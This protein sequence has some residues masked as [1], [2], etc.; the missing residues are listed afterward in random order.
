VSTDDGAQQPNARG[1]LHLLPLRDRADF[2]LIAL[3]NALLREAC[4]RLQLTFPGYRLETMKAVSMADALAEEYETSEEDAAAIDAV[5]EEACPLPG[6]IPEDMIPGGRITARTVELLTRLAAAEPDFALAPLLWRLFASPVG[7][8]RTA[9]AEA[10]VHHFDYLDQLAAA[11]PQDEAGAADPGEPIEPEEPGAQDVPVALQRQVQAAESRAGRLSADVEATRKQLDA[12]R[13][14]SAQKDQRLSR[15]KQ[16]LEQVRAEL[17]ATG[18]AKAA[19]EAERD[20]D[21]RALLRKRESELEDTKREAAALQRRLDEANR[22]EA[23]ALA[24]LRS[25]EAPP[26]APLPAPEEVAA[27]APEP[28]SAFRVPELTREFYESIEEWDERTLRTTFEKIL[29]LARNLAHPSL[30]AKPIE[31]AEGLYRIKIGTDVRL[32]Y[33]R[34]AARGIEILSLIDREDLDRYVR[35]Y[36]RRSH[37]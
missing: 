2:L 12:E 29:L 37:S 4:R 8:V 14:H 32:L 33:R 20:R 23:E 9:A 30:D 19:L 1:R 22:R 28:A 16:E 11:A 15:Y 17:R 34:K 18:E 3:P 21:T 31:G 13:A 6:S 27:A 35:Q 25:A 36:K 10:L 7:S 5:V 26:P 24:Q